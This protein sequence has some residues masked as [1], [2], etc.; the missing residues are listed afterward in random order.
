MNILVVDD[1]RLIVKGLRHSLEQNGFKV[2]AAYDG[3]EALE[4]ISREAVELIL[5]DIMLPEIDGITLCKMIRQHRD[6][7]IIMLTA[8]DDYVDK[9]LGLELGA[10][11]YVT[12]PFHKR[13][14][15][16][17]INA[18]YR[19]YKN[20][21]N[22]DET[23][24]TSGL[25]LNISNR[26]LS[27]GDEEISLTAKEFDLLHMFLRNPGRVFTREILF[28]T[29]WNEYACDTR[30]VDVHISNLREK[31]E[32]DPSKPELIRTKW[33]VGYFFRKDIL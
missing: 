17:R 19:R 27:K 30:T 1:E 28:E 3:K 23:I 7:P 18:V 15:I 25:R 29:I 12:K 31:I 13:E 9:I 16:A 11:D 8:K 10:D 2:F 5:L 24:E 26:T 14:L 20:M 21:K 6:I 33:G 22:E 32:D 4:V